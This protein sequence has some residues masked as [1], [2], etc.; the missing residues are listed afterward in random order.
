MDFGDR[1]KIERLNKGLTQ[2]EL[3][4]LINKTKNGISQYETG[5]REP[6]LHT[7]DRFAEIF[8][9]TID[10]LLGRTDIREVPSIESNKIYKGL[11]EIDVEYLELIKELKKKG[12]TPEKIRNLVKSIEALS[13]K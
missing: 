9:C 8:D 1:L 7:L 10:Y 12:Y 6:D 13:K 4:K 2:E 5:K 3:G 11:K